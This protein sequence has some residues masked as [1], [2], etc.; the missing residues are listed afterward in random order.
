M[1]R[2]SFN[3]LQR[4]TSLGLQTSASFELQLLEVAVRGRKV[5]E[6]SW[7]DKATIDEQVMFLEMLEEIQ[8]WEETGCINFLVERA[9]DLV[10][11]MKDERC[12]HQRAL[13]VYRDI[14]RMR[15]SRTGTNCS[16]QQREG[17]VAGSLVPDRNTESSSSQTLMLDEKFDEVMN[18]EFP[19]TDNDESSISIEFC[20]RTSQGQPSRISCE[21]TDKFNEVSGESVSI[22]KK[23]TVIDEGVITP[24]DLTP[25]ELSDTDS[26]AENFTDEHQTLT[27]ENTNTRCFQLSKRDEPPLQSVLKKTAEQNGSK[28]FSVRDDADEKI[29]IVDLQVPQL[30]GS[31][32][33]WDFKFL[34]WRTVDRITYRATS[35][36]DLRSKHNVLIEGSFRKRCRYRRWLRYYGFILDTGIMLYFREGVF[37]KVADFRNCSN[38]YLKVEQCSLNIKDLHL[39]SRVTNWIIKF[40]SKKVCETWYEIIFKISKN[41]KNEVSE[42][43]DSLLA[44]EYYI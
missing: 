8:L 18:I 2:Y 21:L 16:S 41:A 22:F 10:V 11:R 27:L 4:G 34:T 17:W 28:V 13:A 20:F 9:R 25:D 42:L 30:L 40:D 12:F 32:P 35:I 36:A 39:A 43:H 15:H 3:C 44:T 37:K 38:V 14:L 23:P 26:S 7:N 29:G 5:F 31:V 6:N 1:L 19:D 33:G 24:F